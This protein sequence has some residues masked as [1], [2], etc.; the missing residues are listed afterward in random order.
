MKNGLGGHHLGDDPAR[1]LDV[2][3]RV[4][5]MDGRM[6]FLWHIKRVHRYSAHVMTDIPGMGVLGNLIP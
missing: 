3:S 2:E 1:S 4:P 5:G 6:G